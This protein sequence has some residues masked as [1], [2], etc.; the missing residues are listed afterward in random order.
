[1][2]N[3]S[4]AGRESAETTFLAAYLNY[5]ERD[6]AEAAKQAETS[7]RLRPGNPELRNLLGNIYFAQGR[8]QEALGEYMAATRLAPD[9]LAYQANYRTLARQLGVP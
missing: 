2:S 8:R 3:L 6:L 9:Q 5:Q 4:K 1:M 7:R